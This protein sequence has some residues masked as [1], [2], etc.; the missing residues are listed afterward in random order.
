MQNNS[1]SNN[2]LQDY[3]DEIKNDL[4]DYLA[5]RLELFKL[6][7]YEKTSVACS[8]IVYTLII[9]LLVSNILFLA[10]LVLGFYLGEYLGSYAAGFGVLALLSV[11]LLL[12]FACF[13]GKF[14]RFITNK[15]INVI[16]KIEKDEA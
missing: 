14:R 15:V 6:T 7:A 3:V 9:C 4:S 8:Y 10:L 5:K 11:F 13:A 2:D 1:H 16:R 12:L